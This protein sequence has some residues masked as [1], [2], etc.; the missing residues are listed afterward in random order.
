MI[1][2]ELF[3]SFTW[4]HAYNG[5]SLTIASQDFNEVNEGLSDCFAMIFT[6]KHLSEMN[7][8]PIPPDPFIM[9]SGLYTDPDN[10]QRG[11]ANLVNPRLSLDGPR[12]TWA[13]DRS[14]NPPAFHTKTRRC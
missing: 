10:A 7:L 4:D 6:K 3:H 11:W 5:G 12:K 13:G 8:I 2:H 9:G 1:A 14:I